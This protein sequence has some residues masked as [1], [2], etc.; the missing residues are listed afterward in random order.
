[1]Y[2]TSF[3][4]GQ[5]CWMNQQCSLDITLCL[6]QSVLSHHPRVHQSSNTRHTPNHTF[7]TTINED[8]FL[9]HSLLL[10]NFIE[11]LAVVMPCINLICCYHVSYEF[12]GTSHCAIH[13]IHTYM[14]I[15]VNMQTVWSLAVRLHREACTENNYNYCVAYWTYAITCSLLSITR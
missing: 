10:L 5:H 13:A 3:V 7:C 2:R 14:P 15:C 12:C 8:S 1:M 9:I 11:N 6:R 4:V